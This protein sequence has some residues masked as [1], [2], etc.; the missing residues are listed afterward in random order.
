MLGNVEGIERK[1]VAQRPQRGGRFR[2][3]RGGVHVPALRRVLPREFQSDAAV[4]SRDQHAGHGG[5][6]PLLRAHRDVPGQEQP[7]EAIR[8]PEEQH[9]D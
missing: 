5:L 8:E 4:G 6:A 9:A 7:L 1:A 2:M 3:A